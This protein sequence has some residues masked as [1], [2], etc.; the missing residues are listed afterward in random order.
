VL[1]RYLSFLEEQSPTG[2]TELNASLRQYTL[3]AQR[4]GLAIL[5]SDLFSP[6][7]CEPD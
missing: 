7:G 1:M 3:E 4:P 6:G 5:I 2:A